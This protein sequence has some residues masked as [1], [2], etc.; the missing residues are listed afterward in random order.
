M[1]VAIIGTGRMGRGFASALASKHEVIVGSRD[2]A[3]A[4]RAA[5]ET[6]AAGAATY[7]DAAAD[8]DVVVLTVPWEAMED[9]LIALGELRGTIVV[10]VSYP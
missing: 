7:A 9:T 2:R 8:A 4:T 1:K 3:R 10:D 5:S 6:G